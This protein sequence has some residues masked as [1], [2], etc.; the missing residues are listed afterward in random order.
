MRHNSNVSKCVS[1]EGQHDPTPLQSKNVTQ[2]QNVG[3]EKIQFLQDVV[4]V[5]QEQSPSIPTLPPNIIPVTNAV[6]DYLPTRTAS[7]TSG[8]KS[9]AGRCDSTNSG[10][11]EPHTLDA[12]QTGVKNA[13]TV[14]PPDKEAKKAVGVMNEAM[15]DIEDKLDEIFGTR[16]NSDLAELALSDL[17]GDAMRS[18][19]YDEEI[20]SEMYQDVK[21]LM[22]AM[23][24]PVVEATSEAEAQCAYLVDTQQCHCVATDDSDVLIFGGR[25]QKTSFRV[26]RHLFSRY[27]SPRKFTYQGICNKLGLQRDDLIAMALMLGCDYTTGVHGIGPVNAMEVI[28][29]YGGGAEERAEGFSWLVQL[30]KLRQYAEDWENYRN[31][32]Y[33]DPDIVTKEFHMR[34]RKVRRHWIFPDDFPSDEVW[35]AF[36]QP[37]LEKG[38][39]GLNL[40]EC[41]VK[42]LKSILKPYISPAIL[43]E[44]A[45]RY[46]L[47]H[48]ESMDR[49][50]RQDVIER[51]F[52]V[53][54]EEEETAGTFRSERLRDAIEGLR[55]GSVSH[56]KIPVDGD[57]LTKGNSPSYR[58]NPNDPNFSLFDALNASI[59]ATDRGQKKK[60][61]AEQAKVHE[62]DAGKIIERADTAGI[63]ELADAIVSSV[64]GGDML[65]T[66][67]STLESDISKKVKD[68]S[69]P[70]VATKAKAATQK[71]SKV[72]KAVS[73]K[74]AGYMEKSS[75]ENLSIAGAVDSDVPRKARQQRKSSSQH[76]SVGKTSTTFDRANA[77]DG[78]TTV[79]SKRKPKVKAKSKQG[80]ESHTQTESEGGTL[81]VPIPVFPQRKRRGP[82]E[83]V[84]ESKRQHL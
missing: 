78:Q 72:S 26:Y 10:V 28:Y 11:I 83:Q 69:G 51:L 55:S 40:M 22:F 9:H 27:G 25:N 12:S 80:V 73:K 5:P 6:N 47:A 59:D 56:G 18:G 43:D 35:N 58:L 53:E 37:A 15:N 60:Q 14:T 82:P 4:D 29:S 1:K 17:R 44:V 33:F 63:S 23:G 32:N 8:N 54:K 68:A 57:A 84:A 74:T 24:V 50:N 76:L 65:G 77:S 79:T 19:D 7:T 41:N 62:S 64:H 71:R 30:R 81:S 67:L 3:A 75:G 61:E 42:I 52:R 49:Q 31:P 34:H 38:K 66:L 46:V 21:D 70:H 16:A 2:N 13:K 45:S 48:R 39:M 20:T 36:T